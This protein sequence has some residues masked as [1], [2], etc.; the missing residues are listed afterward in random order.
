MVLDS[1]LY[2]VA[3]VLIGFMTVAI[4]KSDNDAKTRVAAEII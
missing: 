3:G 4:W 1:A 2:A